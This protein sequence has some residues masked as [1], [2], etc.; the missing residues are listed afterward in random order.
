[1]HRIFFF[2]E[3]GAQVKKDFSLLSVLLACKFH[4]QSPK[5]KIENVQNKACKSNNQLGN[6]LPLRYLSEAD[7]LVV[8]EKYHKIR[9]DYLGIIYG[10]CF[11]YCLN[12]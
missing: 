4:L 1:M 10:I 12:Y 3:I 7:F 11:Y 9:N 8:G 2:P 5:R 6:A